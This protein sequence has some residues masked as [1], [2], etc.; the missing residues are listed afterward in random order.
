MDYLLLPFVELEVRFGTQTEKYFDSSIDKNYFEKIKNVLDTGDFIINEIETEEYIN[1]NLKLSNDTIQLKENVFTK[2]IQT[3]F[4]F[5]FKLSINQEFSLN[6]YLDSFDTRKENTIIRNKKRRSYISNNF[7]YDLTSVIQKENGIN[8][9][10]HELEIELIVNKETLLWNTDFIN[11]FLECKIYDIIN[12]VE[13]M[14]RE[15][16]KINLF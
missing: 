3:N 15:D 13:P 7:K 8:K 5:D 1:D 14:S 2:K 16:F 9:S 4:A 12:I 6:S 10:K 11:I